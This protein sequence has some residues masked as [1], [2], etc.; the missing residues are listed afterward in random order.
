M[1]FTYFVCPVSQGMRTWT[2]I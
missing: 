2:C 1:N